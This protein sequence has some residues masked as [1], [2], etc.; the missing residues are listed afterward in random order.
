M[1]GIPVRVD[2]AFFLLILFVGFS[3]DLPSLLS[4]LAVV[5]V[6]VLVHELGHALVYRAFGKE[7]RIELVMTG[8]L[9]WAVGGPPLT[10]ARNLAVS[11]AGPGVG[12]GLGA[13]AYA[14]SRSGSPLLDQRLVQVALRDLLFVSVVWGVL[15]LLPILP[16][17]GGR[18]M[19]SLLDMATKG[20][21]ERPALIVSVVVGTAA[22]VAALAYGEVFLAIVAVI[23]ALMNARSLSHSRPPPSTRDY[24]SW[25]D[26][27]YEALR[28]RALLAASNRAREILAGSSD[29]ELRSRATTLLIWVQ[30]LE[31]RVD[32]ALDLVDTNPAAAGRRLLTEP[33]EQAT[34][35]RDQA[36]DLLASAHRSR[37]GDASGALLARALV[38]SGRLDEASQLALQPDGAA[39]PNTRAV[40]GAEL[41]RSGRLE[42]AARVGEVSFDGDRHPVTA[43]NVACCRARQGRPD[44]AVAWLGRAVDAG[45]DD[46]AALDADADLAVLRDHP[47]FEDLRRRVGSNQRA[48][49]VCYR[50]PEVAVNLACPSCRRPI[51]ERCAVATS[52][53]WMCQ[54]CLDAAKRRPRPP[55]PAGV[56]SILVLNA[57]FFLAQQL[58]PEVTFRFAQFGPL[59]SAGE[60][61]RLVTATVLHGNLVH[62]LFNSLALWWYGRPVEQRLGTARL[63]V[64]YAVAGVA[65]SAASYGLGSC[66]TVSIGASGAI[67][68]AVG[69]LLAHSWLRRAEEP[70]ALRQLLIAIGVIMVFGFFGPI[71]TDNLAHIGGLL[72]GGVVGFGFEMS[73][74]PGR[75]GDLPALAAVALTT[76]TAIGLIVWRTT[77]FPCGGFAG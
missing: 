13:L 72:A 55:L 50:H 37:P 3:R 49:I 20:R 35:G 36:I 41:F 15:N 14:A 64:I 40:V 65:G 11:L 6:G 19:Q 45:Y 62:L 31:G 60:W 58:R 7:P 48:A 16:L 71:P 29:A 1:A 39:G 17:D 67:L 43:Y 38:E 54:E 4:W 57:G 75:R 21:G 42:E 51:C 9:T 18:V 2:P 52:A 28:Q 69:A 22:A 47:G 73:S 74:S 34:G 68:G 61:F 27:G 32:E 26:E 30:L 63:L 5:F 70:V 56:I 53:G 46:L 44:E 77:I 25:L 24:Q 76:A 8:G 33:V 12:F 59:V 23:F 66:L 10:A